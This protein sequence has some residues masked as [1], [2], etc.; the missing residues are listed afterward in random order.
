MYYLCRKNKDTDQLRGYREADLCLCF[1]LCRL[2]VFPWGGSFKS[3]ILTQ[4]K[5]NIVIS[6][7]V[8]LSP[9]FFS[10]P[11]LVYRFKNSLKFTYL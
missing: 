3:I 1:R 11:H 9:N 4:H 7:Y 6:L 5:A 10:D 2:L 8:D